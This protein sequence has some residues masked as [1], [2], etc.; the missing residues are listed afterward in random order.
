MKNNTSK[1]PGLYAAFK[2]NQGSFLIK[3]FPEDA[4]KTVANFVGLSEG[5]REFVDPKSGQTAKRPF[6][7]GLTFHRVIPNFMIQG[8]DPVGNGTGGPGYR[9][10]DEFNSPRGFDKKGILAMANAGPGTNGSQFFITVAPTPW[11]NKKH[12][13][14]G[15]VIEG[16]DVV[17]KISL[18]AQNPGNNRPLKPVIVEKVTI[19]EWGKDGLIPRGTG[20]ASK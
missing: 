5:T 15:E 12:T 20:K 11:L 8:G 17:E 18:V 6:Y 7:D 19:E 3:L 4:P 9:F 2:T 14:F 10:E 16:Y 13:I 1:A